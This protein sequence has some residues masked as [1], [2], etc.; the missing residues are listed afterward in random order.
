MN[1]S[2]LMSDQDLPEMS[3]MKF[4]KEGEDSPARVIENE[5][6]PFFLQTFNNDL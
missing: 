4:I 1:R 6:H 5:I 2:L 3:I